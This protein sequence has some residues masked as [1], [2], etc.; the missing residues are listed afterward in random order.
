MEE[1][2]QA[3]DCPVCRMW[4]HVVAQYQGRMPPVA[5]DKQN[6]DI[7]CYVSFGWFPR[8]VPDFHLDTHRPEVQ[9]IEV[10]LDPLVPDEEGH[11][12]YGEKS[13]YRFRIKIGIRELSTAD[14]RVHIYKRKH[15]TEDGTIHREFL[16]SWIEGFTSNHGPKCDPYLEPEPSVRPREFRLVDVHSLKIVQAPDKGSYVALSYVWGAN[17]H[18]LRYTTDNRAL[19]EEDSGILRAYSKL[20]KTIRDAIVLTRQMKQQ[21][22]WVDS[23][24]VLQ[25]DL[26]DKIK[27]IPLLH[28]IYKNANLVIVA[29]YGCDANAG[30]PGVEPHRFPLRTV[31]RREHVH[32]KVR[33]LSGCD[34]AENYIR[35][36]VWWSRGWTYQE[37]EMSRMQL[38]L[39]PAQAYLRCRCGSESDE[40]IALDI[41]NQDDEDMGSI[42]EQLHKSEFQLLRY[43][44]FPLWNDFAIRVREYS[45]RQLSAAE[46]ILDAFSAIIQYLERKFDTRFFFGLPLSVFNQALRWTHR[47][48]RPSRRECVISF[49]KDDRVIKCP[50]PSWSWLGWIG[51]VI[52]YADMNPE[53]EP[54]ISE[55]IWRATVDYMHIAED[56]PLRHVLIQALTSETYFDL[57]DRQ[58]NNFEGYG[59]PIIDMSSKKHV[60]HIC[61]PNG[62]LWT[63]PGRG[64]FVYL[65]QRRARKIWSKSSFTFAE[66]PEIVANVMLVSTDKDGIC[67][68]IGLASINWDDWIAAKPSERMVTLG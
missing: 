31:R 49:L 18:W 19:L 36:T 20:P 16:V 41:F 9:N 1:A 14:R 56:N 39:A 58:W 13:Q 53:D 62:V 40:T 66:K 52:F 22:L 25:D 6:R 26:D 35:T 37:F 47:D 2:L 61:I 3:P 64:R 24:C 11:A 12:V 60:G 7:H 29:A 43:T 38:I 51:E 33:L 50:L 28:T 48:E 57:G 4:V 67:F 42:P 68:R 54:L 17:Y 10:Y 44:E 65:C 45:K 21:Y 15:E 34:R 5:K 55:A 46:D 30:L 63:G 27:Q 23:L 32:D 8:N 59:Y